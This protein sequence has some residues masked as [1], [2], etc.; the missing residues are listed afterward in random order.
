MNEPT[1]TTAIGG[2]EFEVLML[3]GST[4]AVKI[5]QLP[6]RLLVGRWA[7]LQGDEAALVELYCDEAEGWDDLIAPEAHDEIVKIGSELNRPRFARWAESRRADIA[8]FK[9]MT[10]G[11]GLETESPSPSSSPAAASS[12]TNP[13]TR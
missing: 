12:S 6:I 1:M 7:Q 5:R 9:K 11:L 2:K 4:Q 8:D 3:D 13:S 10:V